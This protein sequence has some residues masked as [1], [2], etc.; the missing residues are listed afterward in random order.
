MEIHI[1]LI[2]TYRIGQYEITMLKTC[3]N[4]LLHLCNVTINNILTIFKN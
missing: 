3:Q 4:D 1:H 2:I